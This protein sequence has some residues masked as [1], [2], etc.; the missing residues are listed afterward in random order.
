MCVPSSS[1]SITHRGMSEPS[2]RQC[3]FVTALKIGCR[4]K[5]LWEIIH[6][7]G[8]S[9][10]EI[11]AAIFIAQESGDEADKGMSLFRAMNNLCCKFTRTLRFEGLVPSPSSERD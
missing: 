8:S 4:R 7:I 5:G 10:P 3:V 1:V 2:F 6:F 11:I 9:A